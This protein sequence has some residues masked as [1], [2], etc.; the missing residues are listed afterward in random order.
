M[1][2]FYSLD[3]SKSRTLCLKFGELCPGRMS[4]G[5][6]LI[7]KDPNRSAPA[8]RPV[9]VF[10]SALARWPLRS[11]W[12]WRGICW[13]WT[14][15]PAPAA[16]DWWRRCEASGTSPTAQTGGP[17]EEEEQRYQCLWVLTSKIDEPTT[18]EYLCFDNSSKMH[19]EI[20]YYIKHLADNGWQC[21]LFN[22]KGVGSSI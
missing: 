22:T 20:K 15:S 18:S 2:C 17:L 21:Y 5:L 12:V 3:E 10:Q 8:S 11:V 6:T 14:G 19:S 1:Y 7:F 16:A 13:A 4:S 9:P